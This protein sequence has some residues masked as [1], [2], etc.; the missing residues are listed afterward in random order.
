QILVGLELEL[1]KF[2]QT[3]MLPMEPFVPVN[4]Y[5][6]LVPPP[7]VAT[8]PPAT[9]SPSSTPKKVKVDAVIRDVK[10]VVAKAEPKSVLL[11]AKLAERLR[12]SGTPAKP[13]PS[14][15]GSLKPGKVVETPKS[16][17]AFGGVF[18]SSSTPAKTG[19]SFPLVATPLPTSAPFES[20]SNDTE[21]EPLPS[22]PAQQ[23]LFGA[24]ALGAAAASGPALAPTPLFSPFGGSTAG[25]PQPDF[26][27]FSASVAEAPP[28][29]AVIVPPSAPL[30]VKIDAVEPTATT[31]LSE[32][33]VIA[34]VKNEDGLGLPSF[35]FSSSA[36][37]VPDVLESLN[38][39][40]LRAA[41]ADESSLPTFDM[42]V[43]ARA[44]NAADA[45]SV[46]APAPGGF[47]FAPIGS[48]TAATSSSAA[49]AASAGPWTCD[50][51]LVPNKAGDKKCVACEE[52]RPGAQTS[53]PA[54]AAPAL[55]GGFKFTP[56]SGSGAAAAASSSA[57]AASGPWTC[58]TCLVPNKAGDKKCVACEEPRPGTQTPAAAPAAPA[59]GG[60]F[61]F[62]LPSAASSASS[63]PWTCSTCLVPNKA[64]VTRCVACEEPRPGV[65]GSVPAVAPAAPGG[66][67]FAPAS[68]GSGS[69]A[70]SS[71]PTLGPWTCD[72]CLVPNKADDTKCAACETP[73]PGAQVAATAAA[74]PAAP[75][76][77]KFT[78]PSG[79]SGS[80]PPAFVPP[81][82]G[83][84]GAPDFS[85]PFSGAAT[86][87]SAFGGGATAASP[88]AAFS[89]SPSSAPGGFTFKPAD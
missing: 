72:T 2:L 10:A 33:E 87:G 40:D 46:A 77:F 19:L 44:S 18:G 32:D 42:G 9:P 35:D 73:R 1:T 13:P 65:Q 38:T 60:G 34:A 43:V 56:Q 22:P 79:G 31:V 28:S 5:E 64:G 88:F 14:N 81:T 89:S 71:A 49:A 83:G 53:A 61:K 17:T 85:S 82:A 68:G 20:Q 25:R 52:P 16:P 12:P 26:K 58:D 36:P 70:S 8:N 7:P 11:S 24:G 80:A 3:D 63:E 78:L 67:K 75:S 29:S 47:K 54:A 57:T 59:P 4:P 41:T 27:A 69:A 23:P 50:T 86:S 76:G 39:H 30:V 74:A 48:G 6:K 15:K 45:A 51:C 37:A 62:T 55:G 66:F 84:G 21:P